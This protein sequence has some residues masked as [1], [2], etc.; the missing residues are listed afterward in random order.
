MQ[1][2]FVLLWQ[3]LLAALPLYPQA[4]GRG[5]FEA[6]AAPSV[7]LH[8]QLEYSVVLMQKQSQFGTEIKV[9]VKN[10]QSFEKTFV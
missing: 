1:C 7:A 6:I 10:A 5:T 4:Y 3:Q 9:C 8:A 2:E